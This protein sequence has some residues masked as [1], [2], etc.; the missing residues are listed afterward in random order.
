MTTDEKKKALEMATLYTSSAYLLIESSN[1]YMVD[2]V[3][4]L[5]TLEVGMKHGELKQ[6]K[7]MSDEAKR[8]K[9]RTEKVAKPLNSHKV[10]EAV[11]IDADF[12]YDYIRLL[13]DRTG[14]APEKM[15][16]ARAL[17]FNMKSELN[18]Y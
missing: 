15:T 10:N 18:S 8:L 2:V 14:G 1:S 12:I 17:L 16:Q 7:I 13:I 9:G 4:L 3:A 6:F 5:E 11:M